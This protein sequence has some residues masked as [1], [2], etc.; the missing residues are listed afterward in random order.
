ML[1]CIPME[2]KVHTNFRECTLNVSKIEMEIH[3]QHGEQRKVMFFFSYGYAHTQDLK[4][5]IKIITINIHIMNS[6]STITKLGHPE[7]GRNS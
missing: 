1:E 3:N 4:I 5:I 7:E 2:Y 6:A